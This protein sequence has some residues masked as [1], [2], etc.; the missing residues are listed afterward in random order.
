MSTGSTEYI[1]KRQFIFLEPTEDRERQN[2]KTLSGTRKL[3]AVRSTGNEMKWTPDF[4][5]V[6]VDTG[7]LLG[8]EV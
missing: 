4:C 7:C 8:E 5:L 2:I 6:I 1:S 3:H